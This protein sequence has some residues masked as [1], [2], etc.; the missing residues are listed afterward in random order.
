LL[1]IGIVARDEKARADWSTANL[2]TNIPV[3]ESRGFSRE[4]RAND[5]ETL[6]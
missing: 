3:D 5:K 4:A 1:E 6:R 2:L